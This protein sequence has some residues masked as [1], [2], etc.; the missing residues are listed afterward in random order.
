MSLHDEFDMLNVY[1]ERVSFD[2]GSLNT[3]YVCGTQGRPAFLAD[4]LL[5]W[6]ATVHCGCSQ[7][8]HSS[9]RLLFVFLRLQPQA[10][11][12]C[13]CRTW[14][15]HYK[16]H[17]LHGEMEI[18][19]CRSHHTEMLG[20]VTRWDHQTGTGMWVSSRGPTVSDCWCTK[21]TRK[22]NSDK[23]I[24]M[25][26]FLKRTHR[27]TN[28]GGFFCVPTSCLR[29]TTCPALG[30]TQQRKLLSI[31]GEGRVSTD[32]KRLWPGQFLF[33]DC[34]IFVATRYVGMFLSC[35]VNMSERDL[36]HLT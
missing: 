5:R 17:F 26:H 16:R 7:H 12:C 8:L 29:T 15:I 36:Y 2:H 13:S 14:K 9:R 6:S 27:S 31:Q 1:P 34:A 4:C 35:C 24:T 3:S 18:D 21:A 28:L 30:L 33:P 19:L 22:S 23:W 25:F 32:P 10:W 11:P 20:D